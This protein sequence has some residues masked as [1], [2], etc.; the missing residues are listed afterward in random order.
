MLRRSLHLQNFG[1]WAWTFLQRHISSLEA[2]CGY[3]PV[4]QL[5]WDLKMFHFNTYIIYLFHR[6]TSGSKPGEQSHL[7]WV[8]NLACKV[9][10]CRFCV[11]WVC[12]P[13]RMPF[14]M[15]NWNMFKYRNPPWF[16]LRSWPWSSFFS[17][18]GERSGLHGHKC[19]LQNKF[20]QNKLLKWK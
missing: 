12:L 19:P 20:Q 4:I 2:I 16:I 18:G 9:Y 15:H 6:L 13:W 14:Y 1:L 11:S 3:L 10:P 8:S 5:L 7:F 17:S